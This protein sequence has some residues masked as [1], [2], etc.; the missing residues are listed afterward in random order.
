[1]Q[2]LSMEL[3]GQVNS[4]FNFIILHCFA[5]SEKI[6]AGNSIQF[7]TKEFTVEDSSCTAHFV[8]AN[9]CGCGTSL[10]CYC[11]SYYY[12]PGGNRRL[13]L[14]SPFGK[15]EADGVSIFS[16]EEF[17]TVGQNWQYS[18][19]SGMISPTPCPAGYY[20]SS[21]GLTSGTLAV[22]S[23]GYYCG[24]GATSQVICPAGYYCPGS[25]SAPQLCIAGYYC[26]SM[27][28]SALSGVLCTSIIVLRDLL[29]SFFVQQGISVRVPAL[30]QPCLVA[31]DFIVQALV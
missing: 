29:H 17:K 11:S 31:Q 9:P 22:C 16:T 4:L 21:S 18:C 19:Y 25:G 10:Y 14:D 3:L 23:A 12:Y 8:T 1:M 27:G 6:I 24:V 13:D 5:C 15:D 20:C 28:L 7:E 2:L 30:P 26:S